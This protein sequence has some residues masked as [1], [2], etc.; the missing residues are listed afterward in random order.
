MAS[1]EHKFPEPQQ[2]SASGNRSPPKDSWALAKAV[3]RELLLELP[4]RVRPIFAEP[5]SPRTE[6]FLWINLEWDS[7]KCPKFAEG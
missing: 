6:D 1:L 7:Q 2:D 3:W 4:E 5:P